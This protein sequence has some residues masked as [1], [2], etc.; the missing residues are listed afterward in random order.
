VSNLAFVIEDEPDLAT[1]FSKALRATNL[2]IEVINDGLDAMRRLD[3]AIPAVVVLDMHLPN[4]DG[5]E[6]LKRIRSDRRMVNTRVIVA[7]ADANM[8]QAVEKDVDIGLLKPISFTQL[9][10]LA[11]RLALVR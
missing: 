5:M 3:E 2:T 6:I 1:I 4:V 7:T 9:R 8:L 10:D 11:A